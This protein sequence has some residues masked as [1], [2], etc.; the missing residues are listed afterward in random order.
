MSNFKNVAVNVSGLTANH[1]YEYAFNGAGG[2]WPAT[3]SSSSGILASDSPIKAYAVNT[4]VQFCATSGSC[5]GATELL[6]YVI[7]PS[8][9][10]NS[11][12][13]TILN[14]VLKDKE[15]EEVVLT[16]NVKVSCV[17]CILYPKIT[18]I[19][20]SN[21]TSTNSTNITLNISDLVVGETYNYRFYGLDG[22]WPVMLSNISGTIVPSKRDNNILSSRLTFVENTGLFNGDNNKVID[23]L[24]CVANK[25]LY[26]VIYATI[27]A[28]SS[29]NEP[30]KTE[31]MMIN[32]NDCLPNPS[33]GAISNLTL[34]SGNNSQALNIPLTNL[35][36]N[37]RYNYMFHSVGGNWPVNMSNLSGSFT[38]NSSS[39]SLSSRISFCDSTG[40]CAGSP[41]TIMNIPIN[42]LDKNKYLTAYLYI[43]PVDCPYQ[44][45]V[46]NHFTVT[47]D[48]CLNSPS[49]SITSDLEVTTQ[50]TDFAISLR[51]LV[52]GETYNYSFEGIYGNWPVVIDPASGTV[53]ARSATE[54]ADGKL[55]FCFPT[56]DALNQPGLLN[57][58]INPLNQDYPNKLSKFRVKLNNAKC[59]DVVAYS[60]QYTTVCDGCLPCLNC[61]SISFSGSPTL[62]LP[63]GC[64]SGTD[65]MFIRVTGANP[66]HAYR[67]ELTSLSGDVNFVPSTGL[68][69]V[70]NNGSSIVPVLMSTNLV[71][72]EQAL[73]QAKLVD[74]D[75]SGEAVDYLG[76]ECGAGCSNENPNL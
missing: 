71:L 72:K 41:N 47:C 6:P 56:G 67:Y 50:T 36:K 57:Y 68:V 32:C 29:P 30:V 27:T 48:N 46:S 44:N 23:P 7:E 1:V 70:N 4:S 74:I 25:D 10:D 65:M 38:P 60:Q 31:N 22:N 16:S 2:N 17:D 5:Y 34:S 26:A 33:I 14:F 13:F 76:L 54:T 24:S 55:T 12:V 45:A 62:S 75:S 52:P 15:T 11:D 42:C 64:C 37:T 43:S 66:D 59:S 39:F 69:Y 49:V 20:N 3:L 19:Y 40:V 35:H 53:I 28:A 61:A 51:N 8:R 63:T 21:L 58:S 9:L 18:T 73:V